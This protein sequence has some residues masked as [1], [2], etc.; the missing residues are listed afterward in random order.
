ME[1][2]ILRLPNGGYVVGRFSQGRIDSKR[3]LPIVHTDMDAGGFEKGFGDI[4]CLQAKGKRTTLS[5]FEAHM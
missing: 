1:L 2:T 4:S 5:L 3:E